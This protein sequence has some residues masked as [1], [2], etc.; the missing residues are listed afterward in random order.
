MKTQYFKQRCHTEHT[1]VLTK[2]EE[3]KI[4][5]LALSGNPKAKEILAYRYTGF[6]TAVAS[7]YKGSGL[8]REDLV[9]AGYIGLM[10]AIRSYDSA[11]EVKFY[12]YAAWWVKAYIVLELDKHGNMIRL[13]ANRLR[14]M[15]KGL[16]NRDASGA[17]PE[18]IQA[19]KDLAEGT[20]SVHAECADGFELLGVL[21]DFSAEDPSNA[22]DYSEMT[23]SLD[24]VLSKLS[25]RD[26]AMLETA[27]G[28]KSGTA[29]TF[30]DIGRENG[31]TKQSARWSVKKALHH[32]RKATL[33]P[34][35]AL[36]PQ[37]LGA[38]ELLRSL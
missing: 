19:L 34:S 17:L 5:A 18:N 37:A 22:L 1:R 26:R 12:S 35:G 29:T 32:A 10:R 31:T 14:E 16:R 4:V 25:A 24:L 9:G 23:K 7:Q 2:A 8:S 33:L 13:P 11:A 36:T 30:T 28:I 20:E 3:D 6:I 27:Y 38:V 15:R 21:Q